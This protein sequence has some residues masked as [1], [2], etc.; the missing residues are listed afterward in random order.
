MV[1]R[2]PA[3]CRLDDRCIARSGKREKAF[4]DRDRSRGEILA[5]HQAGRAR[6]CL[7]P[8]NGRR[9]SPLHDPNDSLPALRPSTSYRDKAVSAYPRWEHPDLID[10]EI[11]YYAA[12]PA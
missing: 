10:W 3:T 8:W 7:L 9:P 12:R 5:T 6:L 1:T 11:N 2:M 4:R